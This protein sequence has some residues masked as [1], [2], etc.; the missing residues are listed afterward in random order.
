[1]CSC[2]SNSAALEHNS[3]NRARAKEVYRV[4]AWYRALIHKQTVPLFKIPESISLLY[5]TD[6]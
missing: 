4:W 6:L 3:L 2:M 1:M 5:F